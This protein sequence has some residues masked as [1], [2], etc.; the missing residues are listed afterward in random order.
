MVET[1]DARDRINIAACGVE[2][3]SRLMAVIAES[4]GGGVRRIRRRLR[5]V[6]AP[7]VDMRRPQEPVRG[8]EIAPVQAARAGE[9]SIVGR[10]LFRAFKTRSPYP[11]DI[12]NRRKTLH[13][14]HFVG[15]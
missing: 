9:P 5:G 4:L 2:N 6:R 8:Y 3:E 14:V 13:F 10:L 1:V 7:S 15:L 11:S 12:P